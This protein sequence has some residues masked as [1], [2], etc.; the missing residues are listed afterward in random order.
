M[1]EYKVNVVVTGVTD[2]SSDTGVLKVVSE[3]DFQHFLRYT[4][5]NTIFYS[6]CPM[7]VIVGPPSV[8]FRLHQFV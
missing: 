4:F 8:K 6:T 7:N 3:N 5:V 2:L 1:V